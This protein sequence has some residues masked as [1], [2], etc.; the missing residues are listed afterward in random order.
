MGLRSAQISSGRQKF[1]QKFATI[2]EPIRRQTDLSGI[3]ASRR[4]PS[5]T[6]PLQG[7][8]CPKS[9]MSMEPELVGE[10][11]PYGVVL[12]VA[13]SLRNELHFAWRDQWNPSG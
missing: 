5:P 3:R 12:V 11:A 1:G 6:E 9:S 4:K 8:L 10:Q 2:A 7:M 13:Y